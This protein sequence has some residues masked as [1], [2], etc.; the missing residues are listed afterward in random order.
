MHGEWRSAPRFQHWLV[1]FLLHL[2]APALLVLIA[3]LIR[4]TP[5]AETPF[6]SVELV[7]ENTPEVAIGQGGKPA[8]AADPGEQRPDRA[9]LAPERAARSRPLPPPSA[10]APLS[11]DGE[12]PIAAPPPPQSAGDPAPRNPNRARAASAPRPGPPGPSGTGLAAGPQVIPARPD[13]AIHNL[14]PSYPTLALVLRQSGL[15]SLTIHVAADGRPQSV[16]LAHSSGFPMLDRAAQETISHWRFVPGQRNGK[17]VASILPF[18]VDFI[19]PPERL[20]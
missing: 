13:A 1:S 2:G 12:L 6:A 10:A 5:E 14:P 16:E 17:P 20:P 3:F 8:V 11:E 15:V 19:P 9:P 18:T 7:E 4:P